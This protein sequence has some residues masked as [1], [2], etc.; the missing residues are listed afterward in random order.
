MALEV[1]TQDA[2]AQ[3]SGSALSGFGS[4]HV[5]DQIFVI[6]KIHGTLY[7]D[8]SRDSLLGSIKRPVQGALEVS[9]APHRDSPLHVRLEQ[10][11]LIDVLQSTPTFE[12]GSGGPP[13]NDYR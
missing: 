7:E 12:D 13:E 4:V 8:R 3:A 10:G 2:I 9:D 6:E 11:H 5:P 1:P